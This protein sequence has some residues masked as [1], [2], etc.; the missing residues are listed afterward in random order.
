MVGCVVAQVTFVGEIIEE[1]M[2]LSGL[3]F[4]DG[5]C[6]KVPKVAKSVEL[7]VHFSLSSYEEK[8]SPSLETVAFQRHLKDGGGRSP[9][10][11]GL[12]PVFPD[13]REKTGKNRQNGPIWP[14]LG[15]LCSDSLH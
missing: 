14:E 10:R 5:S 1:I 15:D 6:P 2:D 4:G 3:I 9:E 7:F 13:N 12:S 8:F 11:T